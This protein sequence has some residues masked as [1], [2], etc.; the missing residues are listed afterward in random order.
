[1]KQC[2]QNEERIKAELWEG[3][4]GEDDERWVYTEGK[5]KQG[6]MVPKRNTKKEKEALY[7]VEFESG[8][9]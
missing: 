2:M 8:K 5:D 6:F 4:R 7:M 9:G 1:M 3:Q